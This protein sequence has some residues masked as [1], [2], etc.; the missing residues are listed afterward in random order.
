MSVHRAPP[1]LSFHLKRFQF[2]ASGG[3]KINKHV[4]FAERLDMAPCLSFP[5]EAV[6]S[7]GTVYRLFAV[8]VHA[9]QSTDCG[10][11]FSFVRAPNDAWFRCDD[12]SVK[13]VSLAKVLKAEGIHTILH[14]RGRRRR[15][16]CGI[17][18]DAAADAAAAASTGR[19]RRE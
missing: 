13:P 1:V 11:Y 2:I 16:R 9:G 5:E 10:H 14:A 19:I 18:T 12:E 15:K 8:L 6:R 3:S 7:G 17:R 4:E